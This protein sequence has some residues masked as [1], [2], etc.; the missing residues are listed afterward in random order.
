M[1]KVSIALSVCAIIMASLSLLRGPD[2]S[3]TSRYEEPMPS[4][5]KSSTRLESPLKNNL[6]PQVNRAQTNALRAENRQLRAELD[7]L[8]TTVRS[9]RTEFNA[10]QAAF[11]AAARMPEPI[12]HNPEIPG[13]QTDDEIKGIPVLGDP[14]NTIDPD[15]PAEQ[16]AEERRTKEEASRL[17]AQS[18]EAEEQNDPPP[19][20]NAGKKSD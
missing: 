12:D 4:S 5:K 6:A 11:S 7:A 9:L 8:R 2:R 18:R 14:T 10:A 20:G 1:S 15:T 19:Q 16:L 3:T 13:V 17:L